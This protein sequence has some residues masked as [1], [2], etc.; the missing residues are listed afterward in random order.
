M[1]RTKSLCL[2]IAA[3][4]LSVAIIVIYALPY[5]SVLKFMAMGE[6]GSFVTLPKYYSCFDPINFGYANFG[7]F[8]SSYFSCVMTV[9]ILAMFFIDTPKYRKI[10]LSVSILGLVLSLLSFVI[11]NITSSLIICAGLWLVLVALNAFLFIQSCKKQIAD[12][13]Y[14]KNK[15]C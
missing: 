1:K 12:K 15:R 3:L 14:V 4:A 10:V 7:P 13:K 5:S 6:N 8:F 9:V 11:S 2:K